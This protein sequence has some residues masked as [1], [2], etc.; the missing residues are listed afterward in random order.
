MVGA[1]VVHIIV[2]APASNH[3]DLALGAVN[4][5]EVAHL[6][7]RG[8]GTARHLPTERPRLPE[9]KLAAT[10]LLVAPGALPPA[11][12]GAARRR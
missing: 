11:G 2:L 5:R 9:K 6:G 7:R 4:P 3:S 12:V 1:L 10:K 8:R